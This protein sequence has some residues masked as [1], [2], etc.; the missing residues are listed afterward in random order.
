[1]VIFVELIV[2]S[3]FVF[4][5]ILLLKLDILLPLYKLTACSIVKD[6]CYLLKKSLNDFNCFVLLKHIVMDMFIL[7]TSYI[8]RS[9]NLILTNVYF[10][11]LSQV[12][13]LN[14]YFIQEF[15]PQ[16]D[17]LVKVVSQI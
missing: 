16:I 1:M 5:A 8:F 17:A 9:N 2:L 14:L 7:R 11:L 13:P 12:V 10:L 3:Q 6:I 15:L 4:I